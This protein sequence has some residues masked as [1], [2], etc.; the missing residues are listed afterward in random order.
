MYFINREECTGCSACYAVCPGKCI[1]MEK[2]KE[3]FLYPE[4]DE[5]KCIS[6]GK[7]EKVCPAINRSKSNENVKIGRAHV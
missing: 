5:K 7:C 4:V 6:C 3:G 2:D 1:R